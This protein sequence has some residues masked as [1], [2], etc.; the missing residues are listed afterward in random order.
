M[1][2]SSQRNWICTRVAKVI[3]SFTTH[4]RNKALGRSISAPIRQRIA[5][6][7]NSVLLYLA[8]RVVGLSYTCITEWEHSWNQKNTGSTSHRALNWNSLWG[9]RRQQQILEC[10]VQVTL[11]LIQFLSL[12]SGWRCIS[13]KNGRDVTHKY[14]W[15]SLIV[16]ET[17]NYWT[18]SVL[19]NRQP[20]S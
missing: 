6:Y 9:Q 19:R 4:R 11:P 20:A 12:S 13:P 3:V 16:S 2:K 8:V 17:S 18:I 14:R 10:D 5:G 7:Q 1:V 15:T